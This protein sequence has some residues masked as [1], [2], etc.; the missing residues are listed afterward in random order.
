MVERKPTVLIIDDEEVVL[1]SCTQILAEEDY[2]IATADNGAL[3]LNLL[4]DLQPDLVFLDLKMPGLSGMQVLEKI[5]AADTTIVA[6]VITGYAT[7]DSAVQAMKQGAFDFLPKPFTPDEF[8]RI[9]RRGLEKR[10]LVLETIALRRERE[11]LREQFAAIVSHELKSPLSAVQQNLFALA[12]EL[13]G[14]LSDEQK[15]R[16]QRCQTRVGDLLNLIQTWLRV[17]STDMSRI[18][19]NFQPLAITDVIAQ[20]V[21]SVQSQAARKD[22][23]I[24][25]SGAPPAAQV[26]GDRITLTE[27]MVNLIGNAIKYS[28]IGGPVQIE[29]QET[30]SHIVV[31]VRDCGV[32]IE[33]EDLPFVFED[34]YVGKRRSEDASYGLGLAITRRIVEAHGGSIAAQSIAGEG[35]TFVIRLPILK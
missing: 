5:H 12:A 28:R 3:G 15:N 26:C 6:I 25:T 29:T 11:M 35:S 21:E 27:A 30:P 22:I 10:R 34:F 31:S 7:I 23:Q 13:S 17:I 16:L 24:L 1:D 2:E 9:T 4:H 14:Q 20:A 32:G 18:Q 33:K 8:R 19:E